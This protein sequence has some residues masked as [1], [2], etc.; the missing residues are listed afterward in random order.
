MVST[1]EP[2]RY[3]GYYTMHTMVA[4]LAHTLAPQDS[5]N[6][7]ANAFD[8]AQT[9]SERRF[10]SPVWKVRNI[11]LAHAAIHDHNVRTI[12]CYLQLSRA[13]GTAKERTLIKKVRLMDQFCLDIIHK[14]KAE[15]AEQVSQL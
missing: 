7:F 10:F 15:R 5:D 3:K 1:L 11:V 2:W 14:R 13:V 9:T 12:P 8:T 6:E 4:R